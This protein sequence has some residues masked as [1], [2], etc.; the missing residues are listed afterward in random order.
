MNYNHLKNIKHKIII[1]LENEIL[2]MV[3]QAWPI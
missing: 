1:V 2:R 3:I